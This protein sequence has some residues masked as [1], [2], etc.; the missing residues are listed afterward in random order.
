[1]KKE[2]TLKA[3]QQRYHNKVAS[4]EELHPDAGGLGHVREKYEKK[5]GHDPQKPTGSTNKGH[6][7]YG[8]KERDKYRG[9]GS[10]DGT[11]TQER[12]GGPY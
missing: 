1:M 8:P 10:A 6:M 4:Q 5:I 7:A 2:D 3:H 11:I 9:G 12:F